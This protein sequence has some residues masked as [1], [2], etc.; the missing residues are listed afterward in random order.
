MPV[1]LVIPQ[2]GENPPHPNH[3]PPSD[4]PLR[5]QIL[6]SN[7][8]IEQLFS[9]GTKMLSEDRPLSSMVDFD[10]AGLRLAKMAFMQL[11][12]RDVDSKN[13]CDF[14][15]RYRYNTNWLWIEARVAV[16]S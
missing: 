8:I 2:C 10:E 12:N 15:P 5:I 7:K 3:L 6:G 14:V 4:K 1:A 9:G 13:V 11:Y 16:S